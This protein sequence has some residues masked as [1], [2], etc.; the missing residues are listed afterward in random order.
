VALAEPG[1][2]L[3]FRGQSTA[4]PPVLGSQVGGHDLSDG[5]Y[6]TN[7]AKVAEEY[8]NVRVR[9]NGGTK[10]VVQVY[11]GPSDL[12]RALNLTKDPRWQKYL[13]TPQIPGRMDLTPR[14]MIKMANQN[15][16]L[17]FEAFIKA[18]K[19][20]I[21]QYDAIIAEEFVRGGKQL[22]I[23]HKNGAPSPIANAIKAR[24]Q[25]PGSLPPR[26]T[27]QITPVTV[28]RQG[29]SDFNQ[30]M[31]SRDKRLKNTENSWAVLGSMLAGAIQDVGDL[32]IRYQ[33][34]KRIKEDHADTIR[35][36]HANGLGVLVIVARA[37]WEIAD[38]NGM[39][40]RMLVGVYVQGGLSP[41]DAFERYNSQSSL[42][43]GPPKGYR[44]MPK[45]LIWIN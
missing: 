13:D 15:Y 24:W 26:P 31:T 35:R 44:M 20:Q 11:V 19:I 40:A 14:A 3:W 18:E 33:I 21:S 32:G 36:I 41:N 8:A 5:V 12:G 10:Q 39:R 28:P 9:E 43:A 25:A 16:P 30:Y 37:E 45:E 23:L 7:D 22:C 2:E 17:L 1:Y 34:E 38:F 27:I 29:M 42:T 6:Y 4:A